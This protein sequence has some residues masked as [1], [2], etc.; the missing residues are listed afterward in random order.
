MEKLTDDEVRKLR[1]V[2]DTW[3]QVHMATRFLLCT[4]KILGWVS[5]VVISITSVIVLF[6]SGGK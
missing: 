6:K 2:A 3:D 5:G 4:G 1:E